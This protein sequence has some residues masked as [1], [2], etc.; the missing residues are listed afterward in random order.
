MQALLKS[1]VKDQNY[2]QTDMVGFTLAPAF[3]EVPPEGALLIGFEIGLGNVWAPN[4]INSV[5][6]IFLTAK[7]EVLGKVYGIPTKT[8]VT[9]KAR[10]GYAVGAITVIGAL[11]VDWMKITF[12]KIDKKV[13][14]TDET[15]QSDDI[16]PRGD[17]PP[18]TVGGSGALVVGICGKSNGNPGQALG[19]VLRGKIKQ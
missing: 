14:D 1:T 17:R 16:G 4:A 2:V 7:G 6:P 3:E 8:I 5:R 13:L 10:K 12:M 18:K 19:L 15:Y 9:V 11:Q